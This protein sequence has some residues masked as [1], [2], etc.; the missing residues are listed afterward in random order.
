[1]STQANDAF[2]L[3]FQSLFNEERRLAF[4]CNIAGQVD[5]DALSRSALINYLYARALVGREFFMPSV[6]DRAPLCSP[7]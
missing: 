4:P 7:V 3:R 6:E 1:M 5:M 2:E